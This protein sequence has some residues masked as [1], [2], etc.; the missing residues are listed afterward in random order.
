MRPP[1][2]TLRS[3][4]ALVLPLALAV[5]SNDGPSG[6]PGV[7]RV[8]VTAAEDSLGVG[9]TLRL[10]A[11]VEDAAGRALARPVTWSVTPAT[12]ASV[13]GAGLLTARSAGRAVVRATSEGK[14][15]AL[16]IEVVA[17]GDPVTLA[18]SPDAW[19]LFAGG[20]LG[21]VA[22]ARDAAGVRVPE[23][24]VTWSSDDVNVARV[25]ATGWVEAIAGGRATITATI[26]TLSARTTLEVRPAA[27]LTVLGLGLVSDRFT[28]ELTVRGS[29]AYSGTWG[30][31]GGNSGNAVKIWNVSGPAPVLRDSLIISGATTTGDVQVSDDGSILVVATERE[32]SIA[33][34]GL[35]DPERPNALSRFTSSST[36]GG[37]H[38]AEVARVGGRLYGWLSVNPD[39]ARLVVVDLG[40]PAAPQQLLARTM[41]DPYIHDAFVRDGMLLTALW[42]GG[43]T[44][45]DVGG[46]ARGGTPANPVQLGNVR[47]VGGSVHNV[48][49][50][51][52]P[53]TA[54]KRYAFVGEEGP[55]SVGGS[56]SGDV[57]VVDV[58]DPTQPRE[59]AFYRVTGAGTH[60]VW[61]DEPN[62]VLY[63]AFY[64]GG[65]HALDVRGDLARCEP[66]AR[67]GE[68][69]DLQ[70]AGR[71]I[72]VA[73]FDR[74]VYVWGVQKEGT[75]V[76]ASDMLN[77]LWKLDASSLTR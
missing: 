54:S 67:V 26:G 28:S 7:A 49:W 11:I 56:S 6:S 63:A 23:A 45:W 51:H 3:L 68:R 27:S 73:Q 33:V 44:L 60:N 16:V 50:Y 66:P 2:A 69:C 4:A 52:D 22:D 59:V 25:N 70:L 21:L 29:W 75:A 9:D 13:D 37:V 18:I 32:G 41:G 34:Y 48:W 30:T 53:V 64:N 14:S 1:V 74:S 40:D 55:G 8:R 10:A 47:T 38:T 12:V 5:C 19:T 24:N 39:P 72:A 65:V 15:G 31:R 57:H 42:D 46:A 58:S 62:G 35:G 77:G 17:Y 20:R 36:T 76:Y 71:R 43:L 61:V